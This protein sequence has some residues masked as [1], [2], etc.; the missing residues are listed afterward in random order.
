MQQ[1]IGGLV[2]RSADGSIASPANAA[3]PIRFPGLE[4]PGCEAE[5]STEGLCIAEPPGLVHPGE[6][7]QGNQ[8][9]WSHVIMLISLH[10]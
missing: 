2:K 3:G 8:R 6:V 9:P 10:H 4:T 7:S 5:V 1:H